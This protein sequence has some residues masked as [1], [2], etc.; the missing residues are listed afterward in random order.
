MHTVYTGCSLKS[1]DNLYFSSP[2]RTQELVAYLEYMTTVGVLL[3]GEKN[4]TE[5]QM[6]EVMRLEMDMAK[7]GLCLVHSTLFSWEY[8]RVEYGR[9]E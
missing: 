7:V 9:V 8:S 6:R 1:L 3:G 4:A 5:K 2:T